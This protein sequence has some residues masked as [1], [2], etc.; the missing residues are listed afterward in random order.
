M[1]MGSLLRAWSKPLLLLL[2]ITITP[3]CKKGDDPL[4]P[5][6]TDWEGHAPNFNEAYRDTVLVF[7][8]GGLTLMHKD[9]SAGRVIRKYPVYIAFA[10]WSPRKWKIYFAEGPEVRG[11]GNSLYVMNADG[12]DAHLVTARGEY[13]R[14]AVMS[15]DGQM[16][17]YIAIDTAVAYINKG[18][19][20]VMNPDGTGVRELTP[21]I[22]G[23]N[24]VTWSAD[25][26]QVIYSDQDSVQSR[27]S[28]VSIDG[29]GQRLLY[30]AG[31]GSCDYP[32]LSP[33]GS[34]LAY[35]G[36]VVGVVNAKIILLDMVSLKP[37]TLTTG[38]NQDTEPSWSSDSREVMYCSSQAMSH[39]QIM[40]IAV[41]GPDPVSITSAQISYSKPCWYK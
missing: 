21:R 33:D 39:S 34:T 11:H 37:K 2:L 35:S 32:A 41:S 38:S 17:A 16:I 9:G 20:K 24:A 36:F 28:A 3:S 26:R 29:S 5:S 4:G 12:T 19:V 10:S 27:I 14:H 6:A 15:P 7:A 31:Y 13:Y 25:S 30:S 23:V 8:P 22:V 40:K 1:I 18:I